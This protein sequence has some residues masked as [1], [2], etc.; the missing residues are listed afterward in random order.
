MAETSKSKPR[1]ESEGFYEKFI[2]GYG[3]DIGV[4]RIDTFDGADPISVE[5]CFHHDKDTCDAVTMD[6]FQDETFDYV[7]ASHILEHVNYPSKAIRN[8][9]R[10][11]KKGGYLI[12]AVPDRDS[13][14]RKE[15]LP[16]RWNEDHKFFITENESF[17]PNTYSLRGLLH[18]AL[19]DL[20]HEIV[21][22]KTINTCTNNENKNEHGNGEYQIEVVIKKPL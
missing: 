21:Y 13:Y 8:W 12:I 17:P 2:K 6:V 20:P 9:Y 1:R 22:M 18:E 10:I 3:I 5:N 4:G 16:S 14:E 15:R 7:Y 19:W 11:C